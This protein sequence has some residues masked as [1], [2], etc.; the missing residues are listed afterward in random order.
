MPM[1]RETE[2]LDPGSGVASPRGVRASLA[3]RCAG[4]VAWMGSSD[5]AE[6]YEPERIARTN[7][8]RTETEGAIDHSPE[9]SMNAERA[10]DRPELRMNA[11]VYVPS[12]R[13]RLRK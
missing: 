12:S 8:R 5:C 3:R 6:R 10:H 9:T 7:A 1:P 13:I 2:K 4:E 11:N